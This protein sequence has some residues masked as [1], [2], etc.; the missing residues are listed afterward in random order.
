M[1]SVFPLS[2][3]TSSLCPFLT[4]DRLLKTIAYGLK[5]LG[6][7]FEPAFNCSSIVMLQSVAS[8]K[9]IL[10]ASNHGTLSANTLLKNVFTPAIIIYEL[11][12]I[13]IQIGVCKIRLHIYKLKMSDKM[14][15]FSPLF[16][17]ERGL[18][19]LTLKCNALLVL[20]GAQAT[21]LFKHSSKTLGLIGWMGEKDVDTGFSQALLSQGCQCFYQLF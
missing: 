15:P 1:L 4:K 5:L 14:S 8:A 19:L 12:T 6:C 11:E 9:N 21:R 18:L 3:A 13:N 20:L 2:H 17:I 10:Q 16:W 7:T